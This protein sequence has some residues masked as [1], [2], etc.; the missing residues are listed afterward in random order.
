M[1]NGRK[2]TR[3]A[4]CFLLVPVLVVLVFARAGYAQESSDKGFAWRPAPDGDDGVFFDVRAF[5]TASDS[6]RLSRLIVQVTFDYDQLQFIKTGKKQFRADY[7]GSITLSDTNRTEVESTTWKGSIQVH[8]FEQTNSVIDFETSFAALKVPPG[9]Y[10]LQVKLTDVETGRSGLR[11][12]PVRLRNFFDSKMT[13]SDLLFLK[14]IAFLFDE[15]ETNVFPEESADSDTAG[16]F[17]YIEVYNVAAGDSIFLDY[18]VLKDGG[19]TLLSVSDRI[20]S[21]GQFTKAFIRLPPAIAFR[22]PLSARINIRHA[23]DSLE[24]EQTLG[25]F[26]QRRPEV[27]ADLANS[28]E[29]LK[30]IADKK[31]IRRMLALTGEEQITA[32]EEFWA[33]RDPIPDTVAN[34]YREEY[35][36][37]IEIA[38]RR[39]KGYQNGWRTDMGMVLIKLSLPQYT[40]KGFVDTFRDPM[41]SRYPPV[42]W[43]YPNFNRRV[44]FEYQGSEYRIANYSE[45]FSLL[46]GEIHL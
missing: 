2:I 24:V 19:E 34:E 23:E 31:E 3:G 5:N 6:V 37:R 8:D 18:E 45:V 4:A 33:Q 38:N 1:F 13:V 7:E 43:Y 16:L 44:I 10:Q 12:G 42:I 40:D 29:Q 14:S 46:S 28:I 30:Y 26:E 35:Y 21:A 20:A 36:R 17:V 15:F 9:D 41:A 39:F 27:Y 22:T 32:F 25:G 11:E